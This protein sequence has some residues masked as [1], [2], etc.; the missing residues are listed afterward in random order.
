[1]KRIVINGATG[2]MGIEAVKTVEAD[3]DLTLVGTARRT[4]SLIDVITSSSPHVV[5][6]L[7]HPSVVYENTL[8]CINSGVH[9]V[10][11]TTGLTPGQ[12][13]HLDELAIQR[14]VGI[15]VAPNFAIGAIL[16]MQFAV[17]AAKY[18]PRVEI[19]EYHHDQKADSPSGTAL[20]T[21]ELIVLKNKN[22][23]I[24]ADKSP[25]IETVPGARGGIYKGIPIHSVRLPGFVAS[26]DVIL[27]GTGETLSIR[28]DTLSRESFMPGVLLAIRKVDQLCGVVYGLEKVM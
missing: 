10:I 6:D 4:D 14:K 11:G 24:N 8:A 20:K 27:S 28:H 15:L 13:K 3:P 9:A 21:A 23:S 25:D 22:I 7:T 17:Q 5:V 1:M 16:M 2:K 18:L 12:L 26:Q 19:I